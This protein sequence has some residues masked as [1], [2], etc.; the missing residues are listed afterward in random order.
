M[1]KKIIMLAACLML[2]M[3][4]NADPI[5]REQAQKKAE[6]Y[7][8]D[9]GGSRR[10]A[11]ITNARKLAPTGRRVAAP[12]TNELYYVFSRGENEGFVIVA[13]DRACSLAERGEL[14]PKKRRGT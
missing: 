8:M 3:T 10:L 13:G 6:Q 1:E 5:T 7:L 4:A 12:L 14:Q 2:A 9:K 11:P